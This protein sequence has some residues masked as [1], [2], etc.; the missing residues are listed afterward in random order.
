MMKW[1]TTIVFLWG[2][3]FSSAQAK[4]FVFACE[5]EWQALAQEIGGD[6]IRAV[7]ATHGRQDP[8]FIR[9][10]PSLMS[11]IKR[12]DL[13]ICSGADLEVGWLPLLLRNGNKTIQAGQPG[14]VLVS[15][16][17]TNIEI[18]QVLDRSLGDIHPDGNPHVHL[19]P[20]VIL[21]IASIIK[22]RLASIDPDHEKTY[23]A[24]LKKF[25]SKWRAAT[26]R[27]E[28]AKASLA[29]HSVVVQ[30][31]SFSYLLKFLGIDVLASIEEKPGIPPSAGHLAEIV[32]II[33]QNPPLAIIRTPFDTKASSN[34]VAKKTG[35]RLITLPY[36]VG[37]LPETTDL[38]KIYDQSI[39]LLSN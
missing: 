10:K 8:H 28:S 36:T 4:P 6:Q 3:S 7:S 30:H 14:H 37:G 16:Y 5:P 1:L 32:S 39:E 23:A 34:W 35:V 29:G 18:P 38:F 19:D 26:T 12:A 15:D 21:E 9:V 20:Q 33:K 31:K 27:W 2:C 22:E 13:L 24:N 17:V 25:A 11:Q